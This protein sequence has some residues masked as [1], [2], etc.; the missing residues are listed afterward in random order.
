MNDETML[1][2]HARRYFRA[3]AESH[4]LRKMELLVDLGLDYLRLASRRKK[5][6]GTGINH[7]Y[8]ESRSHQPLVNADADDRAPG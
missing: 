7:P 4:E 5:Q 6:A 3:A 2:A 1:L 8:A